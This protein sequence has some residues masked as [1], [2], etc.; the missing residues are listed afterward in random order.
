MTNFAKV[1]SDF[2]GIIDRLNSFDGEG[3]LKEIH[4]YSEDTGHFG[5]INSFRL[6]KTM[7]LMTKDK[8]GD[9]IH[10]IRAY[11]NSQGNKEKV[12]VDFSMNGSFDTWEIYK[13][14]NIIRMEKDE[15]SNGR[16]DLIGF[17]TAGKLDKSIKDL[18]DDG[19]F[20]ITRWHNRPGWTLVLES[21]VNLD[22]HPETRSFFKGALL[23]IREMD[24]NNDGKID[25]R[26]FYNDKG[27]IIKV[28]KDENS[29]GKINI[30]WYYNDQEEAV[31]AEKDDNGDG[32]IELWFHYNN[33]FVTMVEE[34]RNLD[35]KADLWEIYDESEVLVQT[36]KDLDYDGIPD[37][38]EEMNQDLN[39]SSE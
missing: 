15:D 39:A 8:N 20:E 16:V 36:K 2:D 30:T 9:G 34:D 6:N 33:G 37:I 35:G 32:N 12:E 24:N 38:I 26:N 4:V 28:E 31:R 21:D 3:N 23:K 25:R 14:K 19:R 29:T 13:S 27:K 18:D 7:Y 5:Q 11:Y 17:Y 10:D 22:G 1:D